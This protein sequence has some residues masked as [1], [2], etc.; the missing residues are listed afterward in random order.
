M[1]MPVGPCLRAHLISDMTRELRMLIRLPAARLPEMVPGGGVPGKTCTKKPK[2]RLAKSARK[3]SEGESLRR[4]I[5]EPAPLKI[6]RGVRIESRAKTVG[7][8]RTQKAE[9]ATTEQ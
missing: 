6:Q 5:V 3:I 7:F 1:N 8:K 4:R 2:Q 9:K